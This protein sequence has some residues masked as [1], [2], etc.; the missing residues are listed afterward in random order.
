MPQYRLKINV[1]D[2]G[3][4]SGADA[5]K[6]PPT[7]KRKRCCHICG[8]TLSVY[9]TESRYCFTHQVKGQLLDDR[10]EENKKRKI[11]KIKAER[12]RKEGK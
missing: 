12:K 2:D 7:D 6:K 4:Y 8:K 5:T 11:A 9:N 1:D 3:V 10:K